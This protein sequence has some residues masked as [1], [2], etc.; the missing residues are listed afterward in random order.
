MEAKNNFKHVDRN[1]I[2]LDY[3]DSV[4]LKCYWKNM[5][6]HKVVGFTK[7][8]VVCLCGSQVWYRKPSNVVKITNAEKWRNYT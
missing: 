2:L 4:Y 6:L 1:G 8:Y 5:Y 7:N 3:G